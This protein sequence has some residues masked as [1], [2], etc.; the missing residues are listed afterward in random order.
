MTLSIRLIGPPAI[1]RD[2]VAQ[3]A[4]RGRKSWAVLTYVLLHERPVSRQ[5][6]AEVLY[7]DADDPL[8]ALRWT[9][10]ELRRALGVGDALRD[11]PI[12]VGLD[13][14]GVDID[15]VSRRDD[16][17][18]AMRGELLEGLTIDGCPLFESW[19]VVERYRIAAEIEARVR[20]AAIALFA[21]GD[22]QQAIG[23]ARHAVSRNMLDEAN[24]E[25]LVRCLVAAGDDTGALRQV[26]LCEDVLRRE[27][28][29]APSAALRAAARRP[30][31]T[32]PTLLSGRS[33][34]RALLDGG[35][36]AMAAGA[37]EAG[38]DSLRRA[39]ARAALGDDRALHGRTL[40]ALGSALVHGVRGCDGEGS[41]VL[42]EAI[43]V[44]EPADDAETVSA[45]CRELGFVEVQAGRGPT[46]GAWLARA[47]ALA[48]TDDARAAIL[49][50]Q[51]MSAS[52]SGHYAL[53][54][55]LLCESARLA[56]R[57]GDARQQGWS[58]S[59]LARAHLLRDEPAQAL[60]ALTRSLLLVE[61]QRWLAFLPW[62]RALK[63]EL[64]LLAGLDDAVADD[65]EQAWALS[66][67]LGDP[68]W[69]GMT[70]RVLGLLAARRGDTAAAEH[71]LAEALRR[72]S[73][74][75]DTYLWVR[76]YV[77]DTTTQLAID[78][79][80]RRA[81]TRAVD[82]L[83]LLAARCDMREFVVRAHL[84]RA[85]LGDTT[86]LAAGRLLAA[87]VDNPALHRLIDHREQ[88]LTT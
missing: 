26:A 10:A 9:L 11:D 85:R 71:W 43:R 37:V 41:I 25:L 40:L 67:Q 17:L 14:P 87:E 63:A 23:F 73:A 57:C 76:A 28:G 33:E 86:A 24:H 32:G 65:I 66:C 62:P 38:L 49:G 77:L 47:A 13:R 88:E 72:C 53:A 74:V 58:L 3:R 7:G 29:I 8:G 2:G 69:E 80:D 5:H 59:I 1:E 83:A 56:E 6:L 16:A 50:V 54:I 27:L 46:A 51:G 75:T 34:A 30:D 70:A 84:H 68:C 35:R 45:A 15:I 31:T 12:V 21:D 52:D 64:D 55:D 19:L 39:V 22:P 61:G 60:D 44:A 4:P 79:G 78:R 20:Q 82:E 18:A 42:Q 81:A 48:T 36:A